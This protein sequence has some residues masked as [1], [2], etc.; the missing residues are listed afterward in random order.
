MVHLANV[1]NLDCTFILEYHLYLMLSVELFDILTLSI[2]QFNNMLSNILLSVCSINM[3]DIIYLLGIHWNILIKLP[4]SV[5]KIIGWLLHI[6]V[7]LVKSLL[8]K[9]VFNWLLF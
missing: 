9:F 3:V 4:I 2:N 8:M 6:M 7:Y 1:R 5:N